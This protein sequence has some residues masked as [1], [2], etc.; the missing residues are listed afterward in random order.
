MAAFN[1]GIAKVPEKCNIGH[2]E[3]YVQTKN[4]AATKKWVAPYKIY[5]NP[6]FCAQ[7]SLNRRNI[8]SEHSVPI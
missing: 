4:I 1:S 6:V 3:S 5:I 8:F 2:N 7:C